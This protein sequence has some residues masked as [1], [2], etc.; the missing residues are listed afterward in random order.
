MPNKVKKIFLVALTALIATVSM[1]AQAGYYTKHEIGISYG[2]GS[3]S[4]IVNGFGGG[5]GKSLAGA[6]G[7]NRTRIGAISAEYF[8]HASKIIGVGGIFSY[9]RY[10]EDTYFG[11]DDTKLGA[12][13]D[14]YFTV[15]PAVKFNWLRK[16]HF[17]MYS[18]LA[19]GVS[20][21]SIKFED[22][23]GNQS[24]SDNKTH[25]NWQASLVGI[26]AGG[27]A[28][29]CFAEL[30]IGEQGMALLGIRYKF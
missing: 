15:M 18:K 5:L 28:L 3:N 7:E 6:R 14:N 12:D 9:A 21:S 23:S 11:S 30:G 19:A 24:N 10:K 2:F 22:E 20:F 16:N 4:D 27:G 29:R 17:G 1:N 13:T 8:Y 26:E 25:F